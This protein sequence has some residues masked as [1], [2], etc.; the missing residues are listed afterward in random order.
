VPAHIGLING[1]GSVDFEQ[2]LALCREQEFV[3]APML[4]LEERDVNV[5]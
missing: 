4:D 3:K 2:L 5:G 1:I